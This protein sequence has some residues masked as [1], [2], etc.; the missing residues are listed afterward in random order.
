[1]AEISVIIPVYNRP[2]LLLE[3]AVSVLEQT[4]TDFEL[5]IVDDGS[6]DGTP[7]VA[8]RIA[9]DGGGRC[10]VLSTQHRGMPGAARNSGIKAA[11]GRYLA[12]LDSDDLWLPEKLQR[13]HELMTR[14]GAKMSHTRETWL[15]E[16]REV[17]QKRQKHRR[18]GLIFADALKKC[19]IG[20]STVM[21]DRKYCLLTGG[22]HAGLEIAEDYEYWLR[23]TR[24]LEVAYIDEALT[25]KRAGKWDQLSE[26]YGKIEWFKLAALAGLLGCSL[27]GG[28]DDAETEAV[29][30]DGYRW[31]GFDGGQLEAALEEFVFKCGVFASGCRKRGRTA[32][33][34]QIEELTKSIRRE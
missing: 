16:G 19:I 14:T 7:E 21:I 31:D 18:E 26:K 3:A 11:G 27:S 8:E 32:E 13:Q 33:A 28:D 1:M 2:E 5:I 17:S 29:Y 23:I 24:S 30:L 12:F 25:V 22:F 6:T 34:A 15:R 4:F 10:R 9:A 20:P